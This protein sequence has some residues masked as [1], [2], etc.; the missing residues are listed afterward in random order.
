MSASTNR[1]EQPRRLIIWRHGQTGHNARGVW[2]GQHDVPLSKKGL[3][4]ADEAAK[5]LAAYKPVEIVASD[6]SRAASTAQALSNV[7]GVPVTYDARM[8]EIDVGQWSGLD[9]AQV[10]SR[11]GDVLDRVDQGEDLQRGETGETVAQVARR[12]REAA[13]ELIGRL[14]VGECAVIAS[15][16]VTSRALAASLV[17]MDQHT[18]WTSLVG[19][20][21]CRWTTLVESRTGWR[22]EGWNSC[23]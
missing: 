16:G 12:A 11:Y 8:R 23:R 17:G 2:Q 15:H 10:R 19:M 7:T 20:G 6:L 14:P 9:S 3:R 18:A 4:Q 13:D 21:N 5:H 1:V 22:I